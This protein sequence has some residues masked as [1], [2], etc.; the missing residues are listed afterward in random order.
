V[1]VSLETEAARRPSAWRRALPLV[2]GS[3]LLA[4]VFARLDLAAFVR[5]LAHLDYPVYV[6]AAIAFVLALLAADAFA[7]SVV[8]RTV[9]ARIAITDLLVLRGSS[10]PVSILNHHAGQAFVTYF[11]SRIWGVGLARA[12]GATLLAY[13]SWFAWLFALVSLSFVLLGKP[14]SWVAV[15]ALLVVGYAAALQL[16]PR[17]LAERELLRPLFEAGIRGH[18]V[19]VLARFPHFAV[20]F[21]GSWLPFRFF[22]VDI[23]FADAA[24]SVPVIM[25]VVTLPLTPQ[26]LGT[27]DTASAF[28]FERFAA[29]ATHAERL[30]QLAASTATWAIAITIVQAAVGFAMMHWAMPALKRRAAGESAPRGDGTQRRDSPSR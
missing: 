7:T 12:A 5:A 28:F 2:V 19:A 9:V 22:D 3:S 10:Y 20:L 6:G 25:V 30:A 1:D 21:A 29:G 15:P 17:F 18:L 14:A 16:R 27:R 23:P 13:A 24:S 11:L 8:Y 4:L 26:G